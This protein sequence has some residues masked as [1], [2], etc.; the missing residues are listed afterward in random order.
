MSLH[1]SRLVEMRTPT[2]GQS[3][4]AL[5]SWPARV[6]GGLSAALGTVAGITPHVLHHI[7]PVAG[8]AILTGTEGS[9]L[10]GVIGFGLTVPLLLRLK[11]RFST[12]AAPSVALALFAVMFTISTLWIGPVIRGNSG[13][14]AASPTE[15]PHHSSRSF[16]GP[17]ATEVTATDRSDGWL[18]ADKSK[19]RRGDEPVP[20]DQAPDPSLRR[21]T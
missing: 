11:K 5:P 18:L 15:D 2:K 12:W 4:R 1:S 17:A 14:N 7:G 21:L 16:R 20:Q 6:L 9:V 8:A 3:E 13:G 19:I 10:F